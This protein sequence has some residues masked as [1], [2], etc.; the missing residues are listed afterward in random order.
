MI[1][2]A[3]IFALPA[4]VAVA[5][6]ALL[7]LLFAPPS[8]GAV[9]A[10]N[11]EPEPT[12]C[13]AFC[14]PP[15][16][17]IENPDPDRSILILSV[18]WNTG[19][20]AT[21]TGLGR[22]ELGSYVDYFSGKVNDWFR[23]Q[24]PAFRPWSVFSGGEYTIQAPKFP[25]SDPSQC[26]DNRQF[27]DE[28]L[29]RAEAAARQRGIDPDPYALVV[30]QYEKNFCGTLGAQSGDRMRISNLGET[31]MHELGHFLG[32]SHASAIACFGADGV[33]KVSL[34][35]N[36]QATDN[37][38]THDLMGRGAG[39]FN[40]FFAH[41]LGWLKPTE[42]IDLSAGLYTR[43]VTLNS[44]TGAL[45]QNRALRLS[46]GAN[47]FWFEL[48]TQVGVDGFGYM[49]KASP[50]NLGLVAHREA[51]ISD[52]GQRPRSQLIDMTPGTF[53]GFVDA[54]L[55]TGQTW[56]NPLGTMQVRL[57]GNGAAGATLII[58]SQLVN[59]PRIAGLDRS[60]AT[61]AIQAAGLYYAGS[62]NVKTVDCD[63][64]GKAVGSIPSANTAVPRG[65][66]V[67]VTIGEGDRS[68]LCQ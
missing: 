66:G 13:F 32:L 23:L 15:P 34:S 33:T 17:E 3:R 1:G 42:F 57:D 55:P 9:S 2:N 14:G 58:S 26:G 53:E 56:V 38:D 11:P 45:R 7:C 50:G 44:W 24:E 54:P 46:D 12:P 6:L 4:A 29:G 27:F 36:C 64:I 31:P 39:A 41:R 20:A 28:V 8:A 68:R 67:T 5:L 10:P 63:L 37:G 19:T 30:V 48:R 51:F 65:S 49:S 16:P 35:G 43:T 18:G 59:V 60:S 25:G 40:A 52:E 61:K 21:S 22:H 47:T 62:R